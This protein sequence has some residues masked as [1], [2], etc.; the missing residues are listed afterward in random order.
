MQECRKTLGR[1]PSAFVHCCIAALLTLSLSSCRRTDRPPPPHPPQTSGTL[2]VPG[3]HAPVTVV[4]D[5]WGIPHISASSTDDLFFAQGFVQAQDRLF[6]LDLWKRSV[7]GR[8]SEVLGANFIQ[9]DSMTR[10]IQ[11]RGDLDREWASYGP[12][13]RRIAVAFTNGINAWVRLARTDV[14]EEFIAAGWLPEFWRPEDL[15]NRTDAFLASTGALDELV[16]ARLASALGPARADQVL[17]LPDGRPTVADPA[18]NLSAITFVVS[19]AVRRIGTPPFFLTLTGKVSGEVRLKPDTTPSFGAATDVRDARFQPGLTENGRT[20]LVDSASSATGA[21]LVAVSANAPFQTPSARYLVQLSAP[22]WNVIGVTSPW[23]PGV[24]VGH[25]DRVAWAMSTVPAD[26]EDIFV[27]RVNPNDPH[28]VERDGRWVDMAVDHERVAVKGRDRPVEYEQQYTS[29]GVVIAED[30][31]R[32]LV[33]TL[34]WSGTEPGGAGELAALALDRASSSA[35]LIDGL[36]HWKMPTA[37]FVYADRQGQAGSQLAGLVPVRAAG[38]GSLP[39][40]GWSSA[41]AWTGF[42]G[43]VRPSEARTTPGGLTVDDLKKVQTDVNSPGARTL[44]A[45]VDQLRSYPGE[46]ESVKARLSSWDGRFDG[47]DVSTLYVRLETELRR[48]M[49][50]AAGVPDD[51]V[52]DVAERIDVRGR[53]AGPSKPRLSPQDRDHLLADALSSLAGQ[54]GQVGQAGQAGR[55]TVTF[56]HPLAVF[57]PARRRF[58][59]GPF[60]LPGAADTAFATDGRAGS[61]F[62]AIFDVSDWNRSVVVNAPGQSGS[63]ASPHYDDMAAPWATGGYVPLLFDQINSASP[64]QETLILQP[65]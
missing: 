38:A 31:E 52:S 34:R 49:S 55:R 27:E 33:Y 32:G 22:G 54:V 65:R 6:Q 13:T 4:R 62:R 18:V 46:A 50:K 12:D 43:K 45:L 42:D 19:D 16:R 60:A 63:P 30:K 24:V 5:T 10:R 17:P 15:L 9:R 48:L 41:R 51:L 26:T 36:S 35:E 7:Q 29:N 44:L 8:L 64:N 25:N 58:N 28:Q 23:L 20:W 37:E 56:E 57:E 3:L 14:P 59:V 40:A 11:F 21:P 53:L 61:V 2:T 39:S 47:R 1:G